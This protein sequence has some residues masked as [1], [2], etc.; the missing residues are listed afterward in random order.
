MAKKDTSAKEMK[1]ETVLCVRP[2]DAVAVPAAG[3]GVCDGTG[4]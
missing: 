4:E 2:A 1:L 3:G